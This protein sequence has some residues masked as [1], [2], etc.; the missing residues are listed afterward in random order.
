[1]PSLLTRV[2]MECYGHRLW[3][4]LVRLA[5]EPQRAQAATLQRI[6][7]ANAATTFGA[8]HGFGDLRTPGQ[9]RDRV[10][11]QQYESLRPFI[12]DQRRTGR[13][14]LTTESPVFY[15]Q[16]SGTTGEPKYIPVTPAALRLHRQEQA[17]F[18]YLQY[19]A[20][21]AALNGKGLGV[22]GAAVEGHL[23]SGHAVGSISGYLYESLPALMRARFVVPPAVATIAD[24]DTRYVAI[25]QLALAQPS[26]TYAGSPNPSTFVRLQRLLNERRDD[27]LDGLERGAPIGLDAVDPAVLAAI[28]QRLAPSPARAQRLRAQRDL[29]FASVWPD[30]RLLTTWTGGSCGVPL[31]ALRTTLPPSTLIMELGYQATEVRG[32]IP[33]EPETSSGLPPLHHHYFE[34]AE[35]SGWNAG[36]PAF[37][38]L[39]EL[40]AG[41]R[42]HVFVTTVSGLYR[43]FMNDIVEAT[44]MFGRTPLLRF[45]QKGRGVTNLTG[46]KLYEAQVI[47]AMRD[48]L[49]PAG[50]HPLYYLAVAIEDPAGYC[51]LVEPQ[52]RVGSEATARLCADVDRRLGDLNLEYR[53]KRSSGRLSPLRLVWLPPGTADECRAAAV[54]S[55]QR[56]GQLKLAVLQHGRDVRP[57]L[58]R[59]LSATVTV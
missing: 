17:L 19:R 12:D 40:R 13:A 6:L 20:C 42:Y 16:T 30:L 55:G 11:V 49:T 27:L 48:T 4:P 56:E 3:R 26:I 10:P 59:F 50:V 57:E 21:P 38:T 52:T 41:T 2:A 15:A 24:Y 7:A 44:D 45:V 46:E 35:E 1:M 31:A 14:T 54:R 23:D 53:S 36:R 25:L 28:T 5:S 8:A 51:L 9:F 22:M 18:S 58:A 47:D 32:T 29:T 34:F 33:V 43:Y 39:D 37:L